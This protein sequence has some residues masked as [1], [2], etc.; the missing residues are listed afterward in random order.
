MD[1]SIK[2]LDRWK[3]SQVTSIPI[4]PKNQQS[5]VQFTMVIYGFPHCGH[6]MTD[7]CFSLAILVWLYILYNQFIRPIYVWY[8]PLTLVSNK[9]HHLVPL[10]VYVS[11]VPFCSIARSSRLSTFISIRST[12]SNI[13][14]PTCRLV[15]TRRKQNNCL[16]VVGL[17][18]LPHPGFS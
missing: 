13:D 14:S 8:C 15:A 16:I 17:D 9:P 1:Q 6:T 3:E 7:D 11:I 10:G 4:R 12:E 2:I 18:G 5:L